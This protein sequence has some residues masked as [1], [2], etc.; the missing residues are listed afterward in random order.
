MTSPTIAGIQ[1]EAARVTSLYRAM[2][3]IREKRDIAI[4]NVAAFDKSASDFARSM[5]LI[6]QGRAAAFGE[7]LDALWK[8]EK[9]G[10]AT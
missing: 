8:V 1:A 3:L 4:A 2:N 7:A 6:E 5:R 10:G 9:K